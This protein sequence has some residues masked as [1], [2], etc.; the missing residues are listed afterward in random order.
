MTPEL[1]DPLT[2]YHRRIVSQGS[3]RNA[4]GELLELVTAR[5]LRAVRNANTAPVAGIVPDL[6]LPHKG[7]AVEVKASNRSVFIVYSWRLGREVEYQKQ[8]GVRLY[9]ALTG[10]KAEFGKEALTQDVLKSVSILVCSLEEM[11][12]ACF[13]ASLRRILTEGDQGYNRK[14][15]AEGYYAIPRS[16]F[17]ASAFSQWR[18]TPYPL[19]VDFTRSA[20]RLI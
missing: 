10:Y 2:V 17:T 16:A 19:T 3:K 9:Y 6:L 5:A 14:G 1:F 8:T 15:Y 20:S 13:N 12:A 18:D 11:Q 4:C 7:S